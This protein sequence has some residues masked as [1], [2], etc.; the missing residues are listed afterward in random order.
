MLHPPHVVFACG[1]SLGSLYPGLSI[2]ERLAER[3][4][5]LHVTFAGDGRP[6]ERH[7][8]RAAGHRYAAIPCR[9][10]PKSPLDSVRFVT[11]NVVGFLAARWMLQEHHASLVVGLGGT[12]AGPVM[13][14][15]HSCA[16]PLVILEQNAVPAV[17]TRWLASVA[18]TVCLGF[19]ETRSHLP[20]SA[21]AVVTGTP[22]RTTFEQAWWRM[23]QTATRDRRA[24]PTKAPWREKRLVVIGGAGGATSLNEAMPAALA[25]LKDELAGWRVVHQTGEGQLVDTERRYE[26]SGVDSLVVSYIDE[27]ADLLSHTDLV[28]CRAGGSTIAELALA[29]VPAILVPDSRLAGGAQ[30]ANARIVEREG[31]A[32][33]IDETTGDLVAALASELR[34]TAGD[35]SGL[36]HKSAEMARMA[37]P[38]AS[39]AISDI[40]CNALGGLRLSP[41]RSGEHP[42]PRRV[43]A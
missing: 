1:G 25:K 21:S 41:G 19:E 12:A 22:G 8:V 9:P 33:V 43:A 28:V 2:A 13:R 5:G 40:C 7:T 14:A 15:A 6:V 38:D 24:N 35:E 17:S 27:M 4:P 3:M 31:A 32:R 10:M 11:D 23:N 18:Q 37:R 39:K 26:Q 29:G 20:V 30:M 36:R 42:L 34:L 16:L